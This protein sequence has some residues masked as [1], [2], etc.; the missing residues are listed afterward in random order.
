MSIVANRQAPAGLVRYVHKNP[1]VAFAVGVGLMT[2]AGI[3][4]LNPP[5]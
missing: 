2:V 5:R 4:W 3:L 1:Q